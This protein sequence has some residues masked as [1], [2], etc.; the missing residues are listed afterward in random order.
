M[1]A[2]RLIIL[3]AMLGIAAIGFMTIGARGN[4]DFVLGFRGTKLLALISVGFAI[5]TATVLFQTIS[6]NRILTPSIMGFDALYVLLQTVLVFTL[7][8]WGFLQLGTYF[9]FAMELTLMIAAALLLFGTLL[10]K[11]R[12]DLHRLILTGVIFGV[13]FRSL[14]AFF[15]R[16]ID[17]N[18]FAIIQ[19]N[20]YARF[21]GVDENLLG[22]SFAL[23][24]PTF[25]AVWRLRNELDVMSLGRAAAINLGVRYDLLVVVVLVIV[26]IL[27][28]VSTALVGPVVFFGL[29]VTSL[30]HQ[31]MP[32]HRHK[33]ILPSAGL[34]A[35]LILV[36]GQTVFERVLHLETTV[37]VVIEFLGG[38]VF[39]ILISKGRFR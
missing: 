34:I 11:G 39:L 21:N 23:L 29:L 15:Q 27:V 22:F 26:A 25:F 7:G 16:M 20:S 31:I 1:F 13:L 37:S 35:A 2:K 14:N 18:E 12:Q 8:I 9:K 32:T 17:P 10:G 28:S 4:W 38:L 6:G 5:S 24:A 3:F 33:I 36:A 30:T 19:I